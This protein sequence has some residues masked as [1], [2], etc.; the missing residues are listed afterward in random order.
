MPP[1][2]SGGRSRQRRSD[3][4]EP[5]RGA[6]TGSSGAARQLH[7]LPRQRDDDRVEGPIDLDAPHRDAAEERLRMRDARRPRES[8]DRASARA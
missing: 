1:S 8:R 4:P 2:T 6:E 5:E 3:V 7:P